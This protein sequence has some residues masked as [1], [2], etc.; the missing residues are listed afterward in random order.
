MFLPLQSAQLAFVRFAMR[1]TVRSKKI[2]FII[3]QLLKGD[4][5][6]SSESFEKNSSGRVAGI[7]QSSPALW[8]AAVAGTRSQPAPIFNGGLRIM[9]RILSLGSVILAVVFLQMVSGNA[10][11]ND[12]TLLL[13]PGDHGEVVARSKDQVTSFELTDDVFGAEQNQ[14]SSGFLRGTLGWMVWPKIQWTDHKIFPNLHDPDRPRFLGQNRPGLFERLADP[15]WRVGKQARQ[16]WNRSLQLFK[17]GNQASTRSQGKKQ[18]N[19][20]TRIFDSEQIESEG[21]LTIN[22]WMSQDRIEP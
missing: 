9:F 12:Q 22:E 4:N 2:S 19:W 13:S 21:P 20:F 15:R 11:A 8:W 18:G 14:P 3:F 7:L 10:V 16:T 1:S 5:D 6:A 17:S